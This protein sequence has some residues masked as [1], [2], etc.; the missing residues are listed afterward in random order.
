MQLSKKTI[1]SLIAIII[2]IGSALVIITRVTEFAVFFSKIFCLQPPT[3]EQVLGLTILLILIVFLTIH[4]FKFDV[5]ETKTFSDKRIQ[6][7][8]S[9]YLRYI[10]QFVSNRLKNSMQTAIINL[11]LKD[12]S[13]K[14][15]PLQFIHRDKLGKEKI[16]DSLYNI[17]E[18]NDFKILLLGAPG[19]GKTTTLL[20]HL[21][22]FIEVAKVNID[23]PI[24]IFINLGE[25][26]NLKRSKT[27]SRIDQRNALFEDS[28]DLPSDFE[29]WLAE[30]VVNTR[31]VNVPLGIMQEWL[32][33]ERVCLFL[34]GL[35]EA[36]ESKR[37]ELI[38]KINKFLVLRRGVSV[39]ICSRIADYDSLM[40]IEGCKLNVDHA[41]TIQPYTNEQLISY[42]KNTECSELQ[43]YLGGDEDFMEMAHSPLDLNIM[44]L[45]SK[46]PDFKNLISQTESYSLTQ[47]RIALFDLYVHAMI[48]RNHLRKKRNL[49]I[50]ESNLFEPTVPVDKN[51]LKSTFKYLGWI[52]QTLSSNLRSAFSVGQV[53][54]ILTGKKDSYDTRDW[55]NLRPELVLLIA[56]LTIVSFLLV[57]QHSWYT[58]FAMSTAIFLFNWYSR[59]SHSDDKPASSKVI[60][61]MTGIPITGLLSA[62]LFVVLNYYEKYWVYS[63]YVILAVPAIFFLFLI[64]VYQ[65]NTSWGEES[66]L[67]L[68]KTYLIWLVL[69]IV[70]LVVDVFIENELYMEFNFVYIAGFVTFFIALNKQSLK[71]AWFKSFLFSVGLSVYIVSGVIAGIKLFT[72]QQLLILWMFEFIMA[73]LITRTNGVFG[74]AKPGFIMGIIFSTVLSLFV[75]NTVLLISGPLIIT[76]FTLFTAFVLKHAYDEFANWVTIMY[77]KFRGKLPCRLHHFLTRS[78]SQ[79]LL[80][81]N[82]HEYEFIH[83]RIRDHFAIRLIGPL[84]HSVND[85]KRIELA[86]QLLVFNDASCDILLELVNDNDPTIRHICITGLKEIGSNATAKGLVQIL[87]KTTGDLYYNAACA[88]RSVKD[89]AAVPTLLYVINNY[90]IQTSPYENAVVGLIK[91]SSLQAWSDTEQMRSCLKQNRFL[92]R[93]EED[94]IKLELLKRDFQQSV[95]MDFWKKLPN[96]GSNNQILEEDLKKYLQ[97]RDLNLLINHNE[98]EVVAKI[99]EA[100]FE[101]EPERSLIALFASGKVMD[102]QV[103]RYLS[104]YR[105]SKK[106]I[107]KTVKKLFKRQRKYHLQVCYF[108]SHLGE[109]LSLN[110]IKLMIRNNDRSIHL[111]GLYCLE[112]RSNLRENLALGLWLHFTLILRKLS[113]S[114]LVNDLLKLTSDDFIDERIISLRIFIK[115]RISVCKRHL[116]AFFRDE[117]N[118]AGFVKI[119][120]KLSKYKPPGSSQAISELIKSKNEHVRSNAVIALAAMKQKSSLDIFLDLYKARDKVNHPIVVAALIE[121]KNP[122]IMS[123]VIEVFEKNPNCREIMIIKLMKV[124]ASETLNS[125]IQVILRS[126]NYHN[127]LGLSMLSAFC[128]TK[129]NREVALQLFLRSN[130]VMA[131]QNLFIGDYIGNDLRT[132]AEIIAKAEDHLCNHFQSPEWCYEFKP[133]NPLGSSP[134]KKSIAFNLNI[135]GFDGKILNRLITICAYDEKLL[136]WFISNYLTDNTWKADIAIDRVF[137]NLNTKVT[138]EFESLITTIS[139]LD[140]LGTSKILST[141]FTDSNESRSA[142]A[143]SIHRR[144]ETNESPEVYV[145]CLDSSYPSVVEEALKGILYARKNFKIPNLL[146]R[147]KTEPFFRQIAKKELIKHIVYQLSYEEIKELI[148]EDDLELRHFA[149]MSF[150]YRGDGRAIEWLTRQ[151]ND[152]RSGDF[153]ENPSKKETLSD[154]A[155]VALRKIGTPSAKYAIQEW[156]REIG[157][158]ETFT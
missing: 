9:S 32:V 121:Y 154:A 18:K 111:Q 79:L 78:V 114:F 31:N 63:A 54:H 36:E 14:I 149:I 96:L 145:P 146:Y 28:K 86:R 82:N 116:F 85:K 61:A 127:P 104:E 157:F 130:V 60:T 124:N 19:G 41:V 109:Q 128:S 135:N 21:N 155:L 150:G 59:R 106:I 125:L 68:L 120:S 51:E 110:N 153:T 87:T 16:I 50:P 108:I 20:H 38:D 129:G 48:R 90:P 119:I 23:H 132:L 134:L 57:A 158:A 17:L 152:Q 98:A 71:H 62:A 43:N 77:L 97:T 92:L 8:R 74:N 156:E 12:T 144:L 1:K 103:L 3:D 34:D 7:A 117:R 26:K 88:L 142:L 47:K 81:K 45:A 66:S 80:Q 73:F 6:Q 133:H 137:E 4:Y 94:C 52:A 70:P 123:N 141:F 105:M 112:R 24:P 140:E 136:D 100:F 99:F 131:A 30:T 83:R 113:L 151:L 15:R 10:E 53:Y 13:D 115:L 44:V 27:S 37:S 102:S 65:K 42:L 49:L 143:V 67:K 84:I 122:A 95:F 91:L 118:E 64:Y 2:G 93:E 72:N 147:L 107:V 76:C 75:S 56:G 138:P 101:T 11:H 39:I 139:Q 46:E 25:W 148:S 5:D 22:E 58:I 29:V 33:Q 126:E 69:V 40:T 89:K 55:V 35:D